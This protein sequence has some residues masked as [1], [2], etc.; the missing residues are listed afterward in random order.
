MV[1]TEPVV[2]CTVQWALNSLPKN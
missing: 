2:F 1:A